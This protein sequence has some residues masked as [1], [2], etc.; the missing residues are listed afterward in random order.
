LY[1][2]K[3]R[4]DVDAGDLLER[5]HAEFLLQAG[6]RGA[7]GVPEPDVRFDWFSFRDIEHDNYRAALEW[8]LATGHLDLA[9]GLAIEMGNYWLNAGCCLQEGDRWL[10]ALLARLD[11]SPS[12]GLQRV[13]TFA[14]FQALMLGRYD[15][16]E[17]FASEIAAIAEGLGDHAGTASALTIRA[18]I[19]HEVGRLDD[20]VEF[21]RAAFEIVDLLHDPRSSDKLL[22]LVMV[23]IAQGD[24]AG[25]EQRLD[26]HARL[27][28]SRPDAEGVPLQEMWL[29]VL[30]YHRGELAR[31][32]R[33]LHDAVQ[34]MPPIMRSGVAYGRMYQ[35]KLALAQG[36]CDRA[37]AVSRVVRSLG[38]QLGD[39]AIEVEA[40][41]IEA[42]A[43]V[44]SGDLELGSGALIAAHERVARG[45]AHR[46]AGA[47]AAARAALEVGRD[48][49]SAVTW[50]ASSE[51]L[52]LARGSV[53]AVPEQ[54]RFDASCA[55]VRR[56]LGGDAFERRWSAVMSIDRAAA[57]DMVTDPSTCA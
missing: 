33:H 48:P 52:R 2:A 13:F 50:L 10:Q 40:A 46:T 21:A 45:Q 23:L 56:A 47:V 19:A 26:Q 16:A 27:M 28:R 17:H 43:A 5:R 44:M 8:S 12:H 55:A 4:A 49:E 54:Q 30:D 37:A 41:V 31:A 42:E 36:R 14:A 35:A 22:H 18:S 15:Q 32:G 57:L 6:P 1:G 11:R 7:D 34:A 51:V 38:V 25:A 53:R 20:A 3:R 24:Y 39:P 9:T 29:G